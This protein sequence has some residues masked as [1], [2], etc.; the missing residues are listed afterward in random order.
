MA[1]YAYIRVSTDH[2]SY[3][4][5]IQDIKAYGIDLDRLDGVTEEKMTTNKGYED[6]AFNSL[7]KKCKPGDI[8][9]AASTDRIGRNFLDMM[10][11]MENA[12]KDGIEI[13]ACKQNLSIARDDVA[14]RIIVA[15]T[16]IMDE[17]EKKRI[18][19]RTANKKAWQREQIEKYGYFIIENGPNAG[20]RCTYVGSPRKEAMS[21][22]QLQKLDAMREAAVSARQDAVIRWR[23][24]SQAVRFAIRKKSE[25]WSVTQI[26][27]ELGKLYDDSAPADPSKPNPYATPSGCRPSKGTVSKWLREANTLTIAQ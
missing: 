24:D 17:D 21:D 9:Y 8:I 20:E 25:G 3:K 19:H 12:A 5:Q 23:R 11:L 2:Q 1:R 10:K 7:L 4:Q 6:R 18:Q 27:E 16:A 13:I 22:A 15:I 14:T 26:A